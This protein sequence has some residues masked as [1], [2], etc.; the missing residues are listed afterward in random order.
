VLAEELH[1]FFDRDEM[2][3]TTMASAP[4]IVTNDI[5]VQIEAS[6]YVPEHKAKR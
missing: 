2:P 1:E 4:Y 3:A 6:A 5:R